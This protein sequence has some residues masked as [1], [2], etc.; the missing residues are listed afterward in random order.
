[1]VAATVVHSEGSRVRVCYFVFFC[2]TSFAWEL[3]F[4]PGFMITFLR[5]FLAKEEKVIFLHTEYEYLRFYPGI[6]NLILPMLYYPGCH[7]KATYIGC[8]GTY[9]YGRK[10]TPFSV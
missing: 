10:V 6:E 4:D 5:P 9:A 7:V 3:Y 8:I 2:A 1:M